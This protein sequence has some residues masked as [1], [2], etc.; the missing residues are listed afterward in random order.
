MLVVGSAGYLLA[1]YL[2]YREVYH[3]IEHNEDI[4]G[5]GRADDLL[6]IQTFYEKNFRAQGIPIT[7][8]AFRLDKTGPL[9]E[10]EWDQ[11]PYEQTYKTLTRS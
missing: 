6:S 9:V 11:E 4:Y 2:A 5:S 1:L 10:P 7:Y 3:F 8:M